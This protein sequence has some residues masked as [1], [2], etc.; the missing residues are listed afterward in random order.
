LFNL[1]RS[2]GAGAAVLKNKQTKNHPMQTHEEQINKLLVG[3]TLND[4]EFF[5]SDLL[6]VSPDMDHEWIVDTGIQLQL[7]DVF[8][9]FAF[10]GEQE[11]F[12]VFPKKIEE[13]GNEF[14]TKALGARD[15]ADINTIIG[16]TITDVK[17]RWNF[18]TELNDDIETYGDKKYMPF[19]LILYFSNGSMLQIAA[20]NYEMLENK[21]VNLQYCSERELLISVNKI[22]EIAESE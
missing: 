7:D 10:T 6:Y 19:E 14:E 13:L 3:K 2:C 12:N 15:V 17:A 5:D 20:M 21:L 16:A 18:Y 9:C 11:F 4:I 22:I 1:R 8:F